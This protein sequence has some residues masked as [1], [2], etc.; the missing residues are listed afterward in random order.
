[1]PLI[2]EDRDVVRVDLVER[3]RENARAPAGVLGAEKMDP[4]LPGECGGDPGI[5]RALLGLNLVKP[6]P[7]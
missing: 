2:E 7:R 5:D 3:E 6:D 1:V 4:R